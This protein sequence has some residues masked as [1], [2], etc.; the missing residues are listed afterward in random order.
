MAQS[1]A[2]DFR[3]IR[4]GQNPPDKARTATL[5]VGFD[6]A[7][8]AHK[9]GAVVGALDLGGGRFRDLGPPQIVTFSR[10]N[11]LINEWEAEHATEKT[12]I[13]LD[14]PTIVP[15][16]TGR[17]PVERIVSSSVGR[18][19]G[20]MQPANTGRSDMF[21]PGAPVWPFLTAF[22]GPGDPLEPPAEKQ[23]FETYPVLALVALGWVL[24]DQRPTGRL[25]KYNPE[26]KT[27]SDSDWAYV[28]RQVSQ[29]LRNYGLGQLAS[30]I[31]GIARTRARKRDQDGLDACLCLLVGLHL[32]GGGEGLMIGD[33]Q[34]GYIVV[35]YNEKLREEFDSRCAEIGV[36]S[37]GSVRAFRRRGGR[38]TSQWRPGQIAP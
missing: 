30:W 4:A 6:S 29:T 33:C 24:L 13:L 28:C 19:H 2:S 23:V 11:E 21:G 5:I 37:S 31:D 3:P 27:F 14:Q 10:A 17:R 26:R 16:A 36:D 20:G 32:A 38:C 15:N 12:L 18:R 34:T 7:W 9:S 35:P 1:H 22:G 25:P 8:T